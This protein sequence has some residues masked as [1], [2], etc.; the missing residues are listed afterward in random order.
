MVDATLPRQAKSARCVMTVTPHS[1]NQHA[2][3][4]EAAAFLTRQGI[5]AAPVVDDAGRHIGVLSRSDLLGHMSDALNP[6][7]L[8]GDFI[9]EAMDFGE[10]QPARAF[11]VRQAMRPVEHSIDGNASLKEVCDLMLDSKVHRLFVVDQEAVVIGVISTLDL[12]RCL[13][14]QLPLGGR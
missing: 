14:R 11:T 13:K 12:V 9:D 5:G 1:I 8:L 2:T 4:Q 3:L 7:Q 10:R 6:P